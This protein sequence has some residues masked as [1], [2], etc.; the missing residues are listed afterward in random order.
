[1]RDQVTFACAERP[2]IRAVIRSAIMR[3]LR[4]RSEKFLTC[5]VVGD[6]LFIYQGADGIH[7]Q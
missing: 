5:T 1:M 6:F 2:V 4:A 7:Q 3:D